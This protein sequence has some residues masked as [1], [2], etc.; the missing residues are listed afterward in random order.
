TAGLAAARELSQQLGGPVAAVLVL[1]DMAGTHVD[2][3]LVVPWSQSTALAPL[4]LRRTVET[5]LMTEARIST[6]TIRPAVQLARLAF[7]LTLGEQGPFNARG[8]G[9]V[10]LSA[11]GERAPAADAPVSATQLA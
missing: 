11:S 6:G 7:P 2:R 1:G 3:P 5:A 8:L 4:G 10:L 9:A